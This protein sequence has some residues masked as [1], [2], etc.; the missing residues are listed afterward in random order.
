VNTQ[1]ARAAK[2]RADRDRL[3]EDEEILHRVS[4]RRAAGTGPFRSP[5]VCVREA[6]QIAQCL[7]I[8]RRCLVP[9]ENLASG[10]VQVSLLHCTGKRR[11]GTAE[12]GAEEGEAGE[13]RRG[14][15]AG[16]WVWRVAAGA[17]IAS[18][19]SAIRRVFVLIVRGSV[20]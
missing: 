16:K 19:D 7:G 18:S 3:L 12:Q 20:K 10:N 8:E 15:H 5:L 14:F 13:E 2:D 4:L 17:I 9:M 1:L 11:G 6:E